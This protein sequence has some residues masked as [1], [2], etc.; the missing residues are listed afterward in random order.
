M[1]NK[2]STLHII[3]GFLGSGKTCVIN[4]I[5]E[6][7]S[8]KK[9]GL[10]LN[11]F[12]DIV[13]DSDLITAKGQ[14]VAT[15]SLSG[16]QIFCSCLSGAFIKSVIDMLAFHPDHIIVESSGLAKPS[17]LM[18]IVSIIHNRSEQ[19]IVYSGMLCVIDAQRFFTIAQVLSML[20]EQL[21]FSDSFVINKIDLADEQE[22][23]AIAAH[24]EK[25]RPLAVICRTTFGR[26]PANLLETSPQ[27][28]FLPGTETFKGWGLEG[29][30]RTCVF[31]AEPPFD[32]DQL[33]LFLEEAAPSFFRIKGF[34]PYDAV[35][36]ASVSVVGPQISISIVPKE[37]IHVPFAL[38]CIYSASVD[39]PSILQQAWARFAKT[40][41]TISHG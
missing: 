15:K 10:L 41:C 17:T 16:G 18:Q 6:Q 38:V 7:W 26:I 36:A 37:G 1:N 32:I 19:R 34:F 33:R 4:S 14:I 25:L 27:E 35:H 31:S 39:A 22:V 24:I 30:P 11:D 5:L 29:R 21:V 9:V 2:A 12:G 8:D 28:P 20:D 23:E 40:A 13:V 3:T